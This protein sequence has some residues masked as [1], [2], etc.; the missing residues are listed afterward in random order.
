MNWI[1]VNDDLP[2]PN[3]KC[4]VIIAT[5]ESYLCEPIRC[6]IDG[7]FDP[8][9]GWKMA[10]NNSAKQVLAWSCPSNFFPTDQFIDNLLKKRITASARGEDDEED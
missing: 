10:G 2:P 8:S 9:E 4:L 3:Q 6:I 7:H 5:R 1:D